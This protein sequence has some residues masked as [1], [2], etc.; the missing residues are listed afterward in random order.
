MNK[1]E[2]VIF[3]V[4][5]VLLDWLTSSTK[6]AEFLGVTRV[7]LF[8]VVY[9]QNAKVSIGAKM[10]L[11]EM[12]AYNG[13]TEVSSYF[14]KSHTPDEIISRWYAK[15]FWLEDTLRLLIE[16]EDAG[17]ELALMSNSW[18]GFTNAIK[19]YNLP[20]ELEIFNMIFDSSQ[21]GVRKPDKA[22]YELVEYKTQT[23]GDKLFF[24][25][26]DQKNLD[27]A[28]SRNWQVHLYN[29]GKDRGVQANAMLRKKLL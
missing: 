6:V 2:W 10:D 8:D 13:W 26:D 19:K 16:L 29:M 22:F 1:P 9:D 21:E 23:G 11:G 25:D 3:D 15:E 12:S 17:Y 18:L 28:F 20:K 27:T 4:G 14:N 5:G 7:E 24:I